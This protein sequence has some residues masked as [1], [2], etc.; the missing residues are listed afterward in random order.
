MSANNWTF[1]TSKQVWM[2]RFLSIEAKAIWHI[3]SAWRDH[4]SGKAHPKMWTL[5]QVSGMS[6][7]RVRR[8]VK[9]LL[10]AGAITRETVPW[11]IGTSVAGSKHIYTVSKLS[12][13]VG[14]DIYTAPES[15]TPRGSI[16][17]ASGN[18]Q[19]VNVPR[20]SKPSSINKPSATNNPFSPATPEQTS[21]LLLTESETEDLLADWDASVAS[22]VF[23]KMSSAAWRDPSGREFHSAANRDDFMRGL[24]EKMETAKAGQ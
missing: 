22:A 5:E 16:P 12:D 11:F 9:E 15:E 21:K 1:V 3:L 19:V 4:K 8:A 23:E 24:A 14:R 2:D 7:P 18:G 13:W 17:D 10:D 6:R 20:I